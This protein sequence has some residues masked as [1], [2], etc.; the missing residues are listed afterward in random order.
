MASITARGNISGRFTAVKV[1]RRMTDEVL[2]TT[3][4][5]TN[6]KYVFSHWTNGDVYTGDWRDGVPQGHGQFVYGRDRQGP[7]H[8]VH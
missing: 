1:L 4:S 5:V 3:D 7:I 8:L 2:L 6:L